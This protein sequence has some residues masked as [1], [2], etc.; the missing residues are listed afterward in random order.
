M[1]YVQLRLTEKA[2]GV[3]Q[4][5]ALETADMARLM[6]QKTI[7]PQTK[8]FQ[9]LNKQVSDLKKQSWDW[10]P[11]FDI[12]TTNLPE[13]ARIVTAKM[14][15]SSST[16]QTGAGAQAVSTGQS[17]AG[18]AP[19]SNQTQDAG[20]VNLSMEFGKMEDA[21]YYVIRLQQAGIASKVNVKSISRVEKV[22][23]LTQS[24]ASSS[25]GAS[26]GSSSS[27][28]AAPTLDVANSGKD[29]FSKALE[30][31]LPQA[32]DESQAL[33]NQFIYTL[34]Q[35]YAKEKLNLNLPDRTYQAPA[36]SDIDPKIAEEYAKIKADFDD[37]NQQ[38][39]TSNVLYYKVELELSLA[40]SN[41]NPNQEK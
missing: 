14:E 40:N 37:V 11:F 31:Q 35:K 22:T 36:S 33:L 12:L 25:S 18:A 6:K 1:L 38:L 8:Q 28:A 9:E 24:N 27:G 5:L 10:I 26:A 23:N 7:D 2:N 32:E 34:Q 29:I 16:Q 41:Q 20:K 3:E 15:A 4:A 13:A 39:N 21:A 17:A 30:N 19:A